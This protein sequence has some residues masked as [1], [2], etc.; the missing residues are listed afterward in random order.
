MR[1]RELPLIFV[2]IKFMRSSAF[3]ADWRPVDPAELAQK[4]PKVEPTAD[5]EAIFWVPSSER[6]LGPA[7][8]PSH[9]GWE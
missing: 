8:L 7:F 4:V 2:L 1:K 5:A 6:W 9:H 3:A